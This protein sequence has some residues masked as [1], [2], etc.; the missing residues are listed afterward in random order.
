MGT[1][2]GGATPELETRVQGY[3]NV[4][5][6]YPV[7]VDEPRRVENLTE[8]R[9][10]RSAYRSPRPGSRHA[11]CSSG[12]TK[13]GRLIAESRSATSVRLLIQRPH[14]NSSSVRPGRSR[15][16]IYPVPRPCRAKRSRCRGLLLA[17]TRPAMASGVWSDHEGTMMDTSRFAAS[18]ASPSSEANTSIEAPRCP[19]ASRT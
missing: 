2:S 19:S 12:S 8:H 18:D 7:A 1:R 14:A 11:P 15:A 4:V 13:V 6:E 5:F 17:E 16:G 3:P 10:A 9:D